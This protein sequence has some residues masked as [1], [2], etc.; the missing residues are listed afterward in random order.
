METSQGTKAITQIFRQAFSDS[1]I[2]FSKASVVSDFRK[3][4]N[5]YKVRCVNNYHH[6]H[7]AYLNIVVGNTYR[8]KFTVNPLNFV[9]E[10]KKNPNSDEN[11][12]NMDRIF[13]WNVRRNGEVAWIAQTKENPGSIQTVKKYLGKN[14]PLMTRMAHEKHGGLTQKATIWSARKAVS[15]NTDAYIPV[16]MKDA[17]LADVTKYGGATSIAVA[18]Y[19]LV[20]YEVAGKMVRSLEALPIYLGGSDKLTEEQMVEYFTKI[21]QMENKKKKV[22]NV[23]ICKKMIPSGSL[24]KYNGFYYYLAGKTGNRIVILS[25]VQLCLS[26]EQIIYAKKI[27]KACV[28]GDFE[29]KDKHGKMVISKEKN[30]KMYDLFIQKYKDS[31][32]SKKNGS[33]GS[34]IMNGRTVFIKISVE[35][36][37]KV[38]QQ[39]FLNFQSGIGVDL[40]TIGGSNRSGITCLNKKVSNVEELKLIDQSVTGIFSS[41]MNLLTI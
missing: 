19:T 40:T 23:R 27:E 1:E 25:A 36:Q 8:V 16:K 21:L 20:E 33:I 4:F 34:T 26:A 3:K 28:S 12:Y 29:E 24:I 5:C 15:G 11:R 17:R 9:K 32:F 30:Q 13:D 6:A 38:L 2:V 14:S 39:V 7:D 37:C 41:E 22:T 18:G 31:I 35:N 10:A